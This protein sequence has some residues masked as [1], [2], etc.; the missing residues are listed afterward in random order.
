M[1]NVSFTVL[2]LA[3]LVCLS[4]CSNEKPKAAVP[5]QTVEVL[6]AEILK[7]ITHKEAADTLLADSTRPL[8]PINFKNMS[9]VDVERFKKKYDLSALFKDDYPANGFYGADR[10]RIEMYLTDVQRDATDPSVYHIKGK[11][12]HK[13]VITNFVGTLNLTNVVQMA[14]P[15]LDSTEL[16]EMEIVSTFSGKGT[17]ELREDTTLKTSG[18]FKGK[19]LVEFSVD[20]KD[21]VATWFFSQKSPT[22]GSGLRYDGTWTS[23]V[24]KDMIKPV[25]W[26]RD[27]F[28]M[29]NDILKDFSIGER[30]V[31]INKKYRH[32]GWASFWDG[33]EWWND[34]QK[35]KM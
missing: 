6:K 2:I 7:P 16:A 18:I 28:A 25:I 27:L 9:A 14:D 33:E 24:K 12:R 13:K 32:L 26:S 22:G 8:R 34:T 4:N 19:F 21:S 17:F 31:E 11:N 5:T 15:N 35:P 23:F 29:A 20:K 1:K 10:Y 3:F 30:D